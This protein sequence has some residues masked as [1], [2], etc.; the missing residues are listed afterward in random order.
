MK[1]P[2][3]EIVSIRIPKEDMKKIREQAI[4]EGRSYAGQIR[5]ILKQAVS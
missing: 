3:T 5:W 4:E 2:E 1:K